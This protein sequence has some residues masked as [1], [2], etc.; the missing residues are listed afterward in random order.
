M[1][2]PAISRRGFLKRTATAAGLA[3]AALLED[4]GVGADTGQV[5]GPADAGGAESVAILHD[6]G[7]AVAASPAAQWAIGQLRDALAARGWTVHLRQQLKDLSPKE[8]G[9][10]AGGASAAL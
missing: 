6:P 3:G 5:K 4:T 8:L 2:F 1:S 7:D 10:V 9:I